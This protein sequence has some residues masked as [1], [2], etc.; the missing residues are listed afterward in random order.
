VTAA[1]EVAAWVA[2]R[3]TWLP[4]AVQRLLVVPL[5]GLLTYGTLRIL[6]GAVLPRLL[7]A[8]AFRVVPL[9]VHV[10][11]ASM[12]A[13]EFLA[14]QVFRLVR[15]R[16]A[17]LLYGFGDAVVRADGRLA[18]VSRSAA[19]AADRLRRTPRILVA[20]AAAYLVYRWGLHFCA[21]AA[22]SSCESPTVR[23]W[24]EA[25][26]LLPFLRR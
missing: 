20:V 16:P 23:W 7:G 26:S 21:R 5:L 19:G 14:A 12:L 22:T 25:T 10:G 17:G 2:A 13:A 3:M 15:L 9:A 24:S 4:E 11:A 18:A 6:L 1:D 8:V